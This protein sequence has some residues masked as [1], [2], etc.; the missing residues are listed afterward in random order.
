MTDIPVNSVSEIDLPPYTDALGAED[1]APAPTPAKPSID[2]WGEV[3]GIFWLLLAVLGFHSFLAKPF[4][5]PSESMMPNL[6]VGD[7]LI[8]SKL[9]YGWSHVSPTIPSPVALFKWLIL[10]DQTVESLAVKLPEWQGRVMGS[11]P[12]RGDVVILTPPGR[13]QDYIKRVIGLPGDRLEVKAG[14]VI[15]NGKPIQRAAPV[16]R[17]IPVDANAPCDD[18][19]Y[20]QRRVA[21]TDGSLWCRLTIVR[22][23]MPNGRSYDTIDMGITPRA[24]FYGPI[25]I[26]ENHVFL[27][28]DNRDHSAD[29]RFSLAENGLGGP[30]PWENIGGR[31]V[32]ITFSLDG[33]TQWWNPLTWFGAL[34]SGRAGTSLSPSEAPK[35]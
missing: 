20:P 31:A 12:T 4:Y 26:P 23:T 18:V 15:L 16:D 10:R 34:R 28:G 14:V 29:S 5:I 9:S 33:T 6:L 3:K 30:V 24:D 27:M 19:D 35:P 25:T 22:E 32:V 8:V 13:N 2:W 21:K 1:G 7:R 17:L 11:L